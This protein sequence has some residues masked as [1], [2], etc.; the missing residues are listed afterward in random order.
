MMSFKPLLS[1]INILSHTLILQALQSLFFCS[2][3]LHGWY[4]VKEFT[5]RNTNKISCYILCGAL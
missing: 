3:I 4:Q 5:V 2:L 1:I